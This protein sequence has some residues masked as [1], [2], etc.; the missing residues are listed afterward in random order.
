MRILS[1]TFPTNMP[2]S[3]KVSQGGPANFA[4]LFKNYI[5]SHTKDVWLALLFDDSTSGVTDYQKINSFQQRDYYRLRFPKSLLRSIVFAKKKCNPEIILKKPIKQIVKLIRAE[6]P[7]VIFLNGF[8]LYN[9][10]LLK[11]GEIAK[12][13]VVIQHAGIWSKELAIH[14]KLYTVEGRKAMENMEKDSTRIVSH[15]IFLNEW[16]KRYYQTN[17]AKG[18]AKNIS[19]VPLPFDFVSFKKKDT[20]NEAK[21]FNFEK[22]LFHIG[23]IARW[24]EIKNHKAILKMAKLAKSKKLPWLFHAVTEIPETNQK[25]KNKYTKYVDVIPSLDRAGISQFCDAVDMLVLPSVFDVSPTVVLEAIASDIPIIISPN[26]GFAHDFKMYGG[27]KWVVDFSN[28]SGAM[29]RI[30]RLL[31]KKMPGRLKNSIKL[32]HKYNKVFSEYL[33]I[34]SRSIS[35]SC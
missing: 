12:V 28:T 18:K 16:S 13:P 32:K 17:I 31:G 4:R 26:V 11:A 25:E 34:F 8:G 14:K 30:K 22:K 6:K 3:E 24:D 15:E 35:A 29:S 19:I 23:I 9:W 27:H 21:L 2:D 1:N 20:G 10:M 7:D 5:V 33:K